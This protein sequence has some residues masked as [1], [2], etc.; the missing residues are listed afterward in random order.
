MI[1]RCGIHKTTPKNFAA[2]SKCAR[3]CS[4]SNGA[5]P[6]RMVG[7][8]CERRPW[9]C[10]DG[11]VAVP[12]DNFWIHLLPNHKQISS[13]SHSH[14]YKQIADKSPSFFSTRPF[15]IFY[16]HSYASL[17]KFRYECTPK[18]RT[19]TSG[20][21]IKLYARLCPIFGTFFSGSV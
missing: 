21:C 19:V 4:Q 13:K 9:A 14:T 1:K 5:K 6:T 7:P 16:P 15:F 10:T 18:N 8:S 11:V 3:S 2:Q 12:V 20:V 17:F